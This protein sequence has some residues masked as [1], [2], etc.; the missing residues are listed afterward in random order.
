MMAIPI[1]MPPLKG[2]LPLLN[3]P[4]DNLPSEGK[5]IFD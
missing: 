5:G 4:L 2:A 1:E 3:M